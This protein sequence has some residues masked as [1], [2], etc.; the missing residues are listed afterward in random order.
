MIGMNLRCPATG[1]H[2]I[3]DAQTVQPDGKA[4]VR[5][6]DRWLET[7]GLEPV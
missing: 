6:N 1:E 3:V 7:E 2:G 5:I 4:L